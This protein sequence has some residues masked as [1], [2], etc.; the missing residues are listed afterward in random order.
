[1]EQNDKMFGEAFEAYG[2]ELF[3]HCALRLYDRDRALE[4]TQECFLRSLKYAKGGGEIRD[5]RPFLYRTLRHL[6]IDE[7]RKHHSVSLEQMAQESEKEIDDYL[8]P[9]DS[10]TLERAIERHEGALA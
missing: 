2:D 9:D 5:L 6:I 1:M 4:I 7:Y 3:R 8:P 10:N